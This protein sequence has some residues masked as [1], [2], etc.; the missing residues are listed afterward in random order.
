MG[1]KS[2]P[3]QQSGVGDDIGTFNEQALKKG[4]INTI[5]GEASTKGLMCLTSIAAKSL[6]FKK[7]NHSVA[8]I[9]EDIGVVRNR[10]GWDETFNSDLG[11][12]LVGTHFEK[13]LPAGGPVFAEGEKIGAGSL[14]IYK[15]VKDE[16]GVERLAV[17]Q[18]G[19]N[20]ED[21]TENDD[22]DIDRVKPTVLRYPMMLK[23]WGFDPF[24]NALFEEKDKLDQDKWLT[25]S[26]HLVYNCSTK[27]WTSPGIQSILPHMHLSSSLAST[28]G[29]GISFA[30][31]YPSEEADAQSFKTLCTPVS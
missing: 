19:Y 29:M 17:N 18:I 2:T 22:F 21:D 12:I 11:A 28:A 15:P 26:L 13:D 27:T 1:A 7:S 31:F 25:G 9:F 5:T 10:E 14:N 4:P 30:S 16:E 24:N 6:G 20:T 23:G 3:K 8:V